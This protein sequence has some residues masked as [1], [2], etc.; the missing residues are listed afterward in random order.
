VATYLV[1]ATGSDLAPGFMVMGGTLI[2]LV[3]SIFLRETAK[4]PLR[5]LKSRGIVWAVVSE[6]LG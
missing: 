1:N 4:L 3:A 6:V 2:S 5:D